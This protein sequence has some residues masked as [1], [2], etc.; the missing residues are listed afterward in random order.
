MPRVVRAGRAQQR[1]VAWSR[2]GS[3][4]D[5]LGGE[6]GE[7][8]APAGDEAGP[9][10]GAVAGQSGEGGWSS[11]GGHDRGTSTLAAICMSSGNP[12]GC[13]K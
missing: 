10:V 1:Q 7:L 13:R 3:E 5:V 12:V 11:A 6:P 8:L 2:S 4:V 9:C